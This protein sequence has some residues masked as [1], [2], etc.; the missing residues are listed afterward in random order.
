MRFRW[1]LSCALL[2]K[3]TMITPYIWLT[4]STSQSSTDFPSIT[5]R[6]CTIFGSYLSTHTLFCVLRCWWYSNINVI[7]LTRRYYG[8]LWRFFYYSDSHHY[9]DLTTISAIIVSRYAYEPQRNTQQRELTPQQRKLTMIAE[10]QLM[11]HACDF[12]AVW[13]VFTRNKSIFV[14]KR[15]LR[16]QQCLSIQENIGSSVF[17]RLIKRSRLAVEAILTC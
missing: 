13:H 15:N 8:L 11:N 9:C 1:Q 14:I 12:I 10:R 2:H 3:C 16:W 4:V 7:I 17:G 6:V 5:Y